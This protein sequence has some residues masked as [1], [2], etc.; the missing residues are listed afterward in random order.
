M[1]DKQTHSE[2][3]P[4]RLITREPLSGSHKVYERSDKFSD[5]QVP[6]RL[7]TLTNGEEVKLYDTSGPYT[8]PT[9]DIDVRAGLPP[10]RGSWC[11]SR[12]DVELY[13]GRPV[14][15]RDNGFKSGAK[16]LSF[17]KLE[18]RP[19]RARA[20]QN[21]TQLHYAR[22]G[23]ITPEMEYVAIRENIARQA[24]AEQSR[25]PERDA[26]LK[27]QGWGAKLPEFVTPEFVRDEIAAGRA[28]IPA[29]INHPELEPMI[30][31]RNF[32]VKVNANI[33]NSAITSSIEE[34][35]GSRLAGLASATLV[36]VSFIT[37]L[38]VIWA[39]PP[40]KMTDTLVDTPKTEHTM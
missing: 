9:H 28:I 13:D 3:N 29:N 19:K 26:R 23:I 1:S 6:F 17:P 37:T 22:R 38:P 30:I 40:P 2:D 31:G 14:D 21:V 16:P 39:I 10:V 8:D 4:N 33:G 34:E 7:V 11:D 15:A 35:V 32:L 27:G 24:A 25:N 18:R 12:G 5:L 20:G 36:P